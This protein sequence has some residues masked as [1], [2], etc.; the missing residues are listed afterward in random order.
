LT[1]EV[2]HLSLI[3]GTSDTSQVNLLIS[4]KSISSSHLPHFHILFQITQ[5]IKC[6]AAGDPVVTQD[7]VDTLRMVSQ[8]V[9]RRA[10]RLTAAGIAAVISRS[11]WCCLAHATFTSIT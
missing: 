10:A 3:D 7:D 8:A 1:W 11:S 2:S 5:I 6:V 4:P 9:T